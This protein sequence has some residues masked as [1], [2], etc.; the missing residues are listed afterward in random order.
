[1]NKEEEKCYS[2]KFLL[3][4]GF[5]LFHCQDMVFAYFTVKPWFGLFHCQD[6]AFIVVFVFQKRKSFKKA[7]VIKR[8]RLLYLVGKVITLGDNYIS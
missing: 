8:G 6:M 4:H 5:G 1:M 3:R 7:T 2:C